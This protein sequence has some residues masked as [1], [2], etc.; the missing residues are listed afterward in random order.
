MLTIPSYSTAERHNK[1]VKV[2][3]YTRWYTRVPKKRER[4]GLAD[5]L[6]CEVIQFNLRAAT[7]IIAAMNMVWGPDHPC[8]RHHYHHRHHHQGLPTIIVA[9]I[10]IFLSQNQSLRESSEYCSYC[11]KDFHQPWNISSA[12]FSTQ[13]HSI[14]KWCQYIRCR[15]SLSASILFWV[16]VI[17]PVFLASL[18]YSN[19]CHISI[20][21]FPGCLYSGIDSLQSLTVLARRGLWNIWPKFS[22]HGQKW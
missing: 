5:K 6:L 4:M 3:K 12:I 19:W 14:H 21:N 11:Q 20:S 13:L 16:L 10:N 22:E 8:D 2:A 15:I 17:L 1:E 7:I 9:T 18:F